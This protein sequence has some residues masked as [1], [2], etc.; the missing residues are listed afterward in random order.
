MLPLISRTILQTF[1]CVT[2]N[3]EDEFTD[4]M[5]VQSVDPNVD[6]S[7]AEYD[8]MISYAA[9]NV[10][11][12]PV[13]VP[14]GLFLTFIRAVEHLDPPGIPEA[15]AIENRT[16]NE[17]IKSSAVA[18]LALKY[19]PRYWYYEIVFNLSRRLALTCFALV[20]RTRG[21]F[22]LFVLVVSI[23]TTVSERE[24]NAFIDPYLGAF[25]YLM[26]WQIQ[27]CILALL[28]MDAEMTDDIGDSIVGV[29]L[30]IVNVL[31]MGI[32]FLDTRGEEARKKLEQ[33][34]ALR[35]RVGRQTFR[36]SLF[37]NGARELS[38]NPTSVTPALSAAVDA[39][40]D[41]ESGSDSDSA[42]KES[43]LGG[44]DNS[45]GF[46]ADA[47]EIVYRN[48][49]SHGD[50][51][52]GMS[53]GGAVRGSIGTAMEPE[54]RYDSEVVRAIV[55]RDMPHGGEVLVIDE[56][57][58]S[59]HRIPVPPG[60]KKGDTCSLEVPIKS[61][62]LPVKVP[63]DMP[64]GG[65]VIVTDRKSGKTMRIPIPS[66]AFA[67]DSCT[68]EVPVLLP[69]AEAEAS[70]E[71]VV[72]EEEEEEE[73]EEE[74]S[75]GAEEE[76]ALFANFLIFHDL[77][78]YGEDLRDHGVDSLADLYDEHIVQDGDLEEIG[79]SDAEIKRFRAVLA[80]QPLY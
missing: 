63:V 2:Y 39:E 59:E 19:K 75:D 11:I 72:V 44:T 58:G 51:D 50:I 78:P 4:Q 29:S 5:K 73:E 30:L 61:K 6:C 33:L 49:A 67:G 38:S 45:D 52:D 37:R 76:R 24:M 70:V 66:G 57:T 13:G 55:G 53:S 10:L 18:F 21:S 12:W 1:R 22:I 65:V 69:S 26:S 32:V 20:F 47:D 16:S 35:R 54:V 31:M 77:Q 71:V 62:V 27:L 17:Y 15:R 7:S 41:D 3:E 36:V 23:L 34:A 56:V 79:M 80:S 74:A 46:D 14:I 25:V 42:N 68:L 64:K 48:G 8:R 43:R 9:V 60:A 28:L 40:A